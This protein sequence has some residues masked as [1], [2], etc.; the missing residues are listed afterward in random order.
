MRPIWIRWNSSGLLIPVVSFKFT[1]L[2]EDVGKRRVRAVPITRGSKITDMLKDETKAATTAAL[3][4]IIKI[5]CFIIN[6]SLHACSITTSKHICFSAFQTGKE[7]S[8]RKM[9]LITVNIVA[10]ESCTIGGATGAIAPNMSMVSVV[11]CVTVYLNMAPV[12]GVRS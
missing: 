4:E 1:Q 6:T 2:A 11:P 12:F 10:P 9:A 3:Y 8:P 7:N 5:N